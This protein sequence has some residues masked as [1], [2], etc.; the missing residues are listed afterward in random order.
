MSGLNVIG[1]DESRLNVIGLNVDGLDMS[2]VGG[3]GVDVRWLDINGLVMIGGPNM[4][5]LA[6]GGLYVSLLSLGNNRFDELWLL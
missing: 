2:G 4:R 1:L 6:N 3:C 5:R